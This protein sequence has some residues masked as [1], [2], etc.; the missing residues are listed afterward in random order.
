MYITFN[1]HNIWA[2]PGDEGDQSAKGLYQ[3]PDLLRIGECLYIAFDQYKV[4]FEKNYDWV[5]VDPNVARYDAQLLRLQVE[6]TKNLDA[7]VAEN[8]K[9]PTLWQK[10][11]RKKPD[12]LDFVDMVEALSTAIKEKGITDFYLYQ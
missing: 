12:T 1:D 9:Q 4:L 5:A 11:R 3:V 10:I 7:Y 2:F 8:T 6:D